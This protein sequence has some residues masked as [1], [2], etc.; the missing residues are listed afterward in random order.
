MFASVTRAV[1]YGQAPEKLKVIFVEGDHIG[2]RLQ[3][4]G[5]GER[6]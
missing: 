4:Q 5:I 2:Q 1:E 3:I 6:T